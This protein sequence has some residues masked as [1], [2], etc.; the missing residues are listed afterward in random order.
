MK[1]THTMRGLIG[2]AVALLLVSSASAQ[3]MAPTKAQVIRTSG[4]ARFTTGNNVWQP[5]KVGDVYGAGTVIQTDTSDKSYVDL[6]LG[7]GKAAVNSEYSAGPEIAPITA[8][9][10]SYQPKSEQNVV[11]V[12]GNTALG[13]DNLTTSHT[14]ADVVS[15]TQLDLKQGHIFGTVKKMT[16]GSRYEIKLPNGVAGIR[17]TCYDLWSDGRFRIGNGSGA[18]SLMGTDNQPNTK[19]VPGGYEYNPTTDQLSPLPPGA[20]NSMLRLEQDVRVFGT[21]QTVFFT[22]D[23]TVHHVSPHHGHHHL[24]E[25]GDHDQNHDND[26]DGD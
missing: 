20:L 22:A 7:D 17:G 19:V 14:G 12:Y 8:S 6:V 24:D 16:A 23:H 25:D 21:P 1:D 13:I 11:R 3:K 26:D 15:D 18:I 10:A 2:C 9:V 5:V 4:K